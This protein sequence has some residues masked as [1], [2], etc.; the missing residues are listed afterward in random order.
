MRHGKPH[1][2][3]RSVPIAEWPEPDRLAWEAACRRG[4]RLRRGGAAAHLKPIT[5]GDLAR[6][7][8]YFVDH[9]QRAKIGISSTEPAGMV[10]PQN[11]SSYLEEMRDRVGSVT[12]HG[13]IYKLRRMVEL[14][15]PSRDVGWLREIENDLDCAKIPRSKYPRLVAASSLVAVGMEMF[16]QAERLLHENADSKS[17][18]LQRR[19][20]LRRARGI[21]DRR[22]LTAAALARDGVLMALL[23]LCPIRLKNLAALTLEVSLKKIGDSWWIT[24]PN[25]ETK[26]ERWDERPVPGLLTPLLD[27]YVEHYRPLLSR[28]RADPGSGA[29]WISSSTGQ[30]MTSSGV[31]GA[32][33]RSTRIAFGHEIGPHMFRTA[34]AT[35]AAVRATSMPALASALLQHRGPTV[36]EAH[37]NRATSHQASQEYAKVLRFV[38]NDG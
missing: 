38:R 28:L 37:Y 3:V 12:L 29:V 24:L 31:E 14:I 30:A 35:E 33:R 5:Q 21:A 6:R 36:T 7:Y 22:Q 23:A 27:R 34:A 4:G 10:T 26:S 25:E 18:R 15:A 20:V 2:T 1:Y 9:L 11:V 19:A 17:R 8:G 16:E 13:S 32:I